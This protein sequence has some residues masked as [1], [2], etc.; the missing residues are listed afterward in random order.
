M[1]SPER[2][3]EIR[4]KVK[5]PVELH[6]PNKH[7]PQ[8]GA[9]A[10]LSLNGCYIES[11]L[12]LPKGTVVQLK[13]QLNRTIVV[14]GTVVTSDP[15]VGNGIRFDGMLPADNQELRAFLEAAQKE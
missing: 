3:E 10:D 5:V 14:S 9:T 7:A 4:L 13:L 11:F 12:P 1:P 2:R 6:L 15:Q 8:R